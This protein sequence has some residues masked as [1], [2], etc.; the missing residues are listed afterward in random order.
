LLQRPHHLL[1]PRPT[2]HRARQTLPTETLK[3]PRRIHRRLPRQRPHPQRLHHRPR[4]PRMPQDMIVQPRRNPKRLLCGHSFQ[5]P[6]RLIPNFLRQQ[7]ECFIHSRTSCAIQDELCRGD[8][9]VA[10]NV[11]QRHRGTEKE[12]ESC[13]ADGGQMHTYGKNSLN[14]SVSICGLSVANSSLCFFSV[15]LCLCGTF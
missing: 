2:L 5:Y 15:T 11:P 14:L 13:A 3:P 9:C 7:N 12:E 4:M 6:Q 1:Q 10:L 8:A